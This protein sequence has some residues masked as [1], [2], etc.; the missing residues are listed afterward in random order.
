MKERR[1]DRVIYLDADNRAR[2][3]DPRAP[4]EIPRVSTLPPGMSEAERNGH[5]LG[6]V[7][8]LACAA[9]MVEELPLAMQALALASGAGLC[10]IS[11][12]LAVRRA[13]KR[14]AR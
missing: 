5:V 9:C 2:V 14:S 13:R 3:V 7:I 1:T 10:W 6:A 12:R 11:W 8:G 4:L